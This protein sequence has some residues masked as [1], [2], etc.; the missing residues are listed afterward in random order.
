MGNQPPKGSKKGLCQTP[1]R[2]VPKE[3]PHGKGEAAAHPDVA[4]ADGKAIVKPD[5]AGNR[6]EKKI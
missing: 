4:T 6:N 3:D 5:P 2:S 1:Y